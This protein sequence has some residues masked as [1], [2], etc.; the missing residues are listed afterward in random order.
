MTPSND[1][2]STVAEAD[3]ELQRKET[4]ST[5][6]TMGSILQDIQGVESRPSTADKRFTFFP[7]LPTEL[8]LEIWEM[9][10]PDPSIL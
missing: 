5:S 3:P 8:R 7:K 9:A 1:G 2:K 4:T 10:L 6:G